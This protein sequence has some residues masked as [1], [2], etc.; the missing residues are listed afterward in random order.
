MKRGSIL[1]YSLLRVG[2]FVVLLLLLMLLGIWPWLAAVVAAVIAL[3]ISIIFL[4]APRSEVSQAIH[5]RRSRGR[6]DADSD[7]EDAAVGPEV[8]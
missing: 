7:A 1:L 5:D 3:C 8:D 6:V 4:N 2:I